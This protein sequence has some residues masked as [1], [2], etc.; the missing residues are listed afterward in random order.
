[1]LCW[2]IIA[3]PATSLLPPLRRGDTYF[4]IT[5][6]RR[7]PLCFPSGR[8]LP[9]VREAGEEQ[10]PSFTSGRRVDLGRGLAVSLALAG[11]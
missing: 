10:Q 1:M 4:S 11:M 6:C 3:D 2:A 7:E 9:E 8:Q 5:L